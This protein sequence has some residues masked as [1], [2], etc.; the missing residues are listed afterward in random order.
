MAASPGRMRPGVGSFGAIGHPQIFGGDM[1]QK[2]HPLLPLAG[3][4]HIAHTDSSQLF[5][6]PV[7]IDEY[8]LLFLFG[9]EVLKKIRE[10][11]TSTHL[12]Y[13]YL[14]L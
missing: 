4:A 14:Y 5:E 11:G 1:R 6:Q 3:P 10:H 8:S 12:H 9:K 13:T 7:F 2:A